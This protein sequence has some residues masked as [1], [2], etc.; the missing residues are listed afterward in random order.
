MCIEQR[1]STTTKRER[2]ERERREME[3]DLRVGGKVEGRVREWEE[4]V[5]L[6]VH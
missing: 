3:A 4:Q 2:H 6:P 5:H 1:S